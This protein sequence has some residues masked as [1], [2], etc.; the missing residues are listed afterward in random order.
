MSDKFGNP[1]S[2]KQAIKGLENLYKLYLGVESRRTEGNW[3]DE[4]R[5]Q[6]SCRYDLYMNY[7]LIIKGNMCKE[8]KEIFKVLGFGVKKEELLLKFNLFSSE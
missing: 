1:F 8:D 5:K 3:L 2:V 7:V 4:L 6:S